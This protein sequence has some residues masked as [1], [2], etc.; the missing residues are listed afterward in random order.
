MRGR[1][2]CPLANGYRM[3]QDIDELGIFFTTG[4][5]NSGLNLRVLKES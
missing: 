4:F 1:F 2:F 3:G 5:K